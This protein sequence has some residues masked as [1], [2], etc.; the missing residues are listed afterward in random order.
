MRARW[1]VPGCLIWALAATAQDTREQISI[2]SDRAVFEEN[3]GVYIGNVQLDQGG[4]QIRADTLQLMTENK[5]VRKVIATGGPARFTRKGDAKEGAVSAAA[6]AVEYDLA[7]EVITLTGNARIDRQGSLIE[8]TRIVY[9]A[10]SRVVN[11]VARG[12]TGG[13]VN[14]VLQPLRDS[15][16]GNESDSGDSNPGSR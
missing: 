8:G 16:A 14:M 5:S 6:S 3:H 7:S 2:S 13:R 15:D 10:K 4:M 11:A 12:E 9:N 1:L